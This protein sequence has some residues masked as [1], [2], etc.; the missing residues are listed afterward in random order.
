VKRLIEAALRRG[1]RKG[2]SDGVLDGNRAW[3]VVG[4]LALVGHLAGRALGRDQDVVFSEK[5][6]PGESFLVTH[7]PQ[8]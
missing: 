7:L 1:M 4:G 6:A 5:I 8:A 3:I 2:W